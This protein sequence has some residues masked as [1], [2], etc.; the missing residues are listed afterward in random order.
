MLDYYDRLNVA[1]LEGDLLKTARAALSAAETP[2]ADL[3][4]VHQP[5]L[6]GVVSFSA[7][8]IRAYRASA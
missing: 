8:E 1:E 5:T 4:A 6:V 7:E 3:P 2:R